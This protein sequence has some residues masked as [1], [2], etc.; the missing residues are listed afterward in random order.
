M[1][2]NLL[3]DNITII[4]P[5][6]KQEAGWSV[7]V[8]IPSELIGKTA[9]VVVEGFDYTKR[10]SFQLKFDISLSEFLNEVIDQ[11]IDYIQSIVEDENDTRR[12]Y[13][14][15]QIFLEI[16]DLDTQTMVLQAEFGS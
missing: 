13:F 14:L 10:K 1:N 3:P 6:Y 12:E 8:D 2:I 4:V 7:Y 5:E 15:E 9:S 16:L 11:I